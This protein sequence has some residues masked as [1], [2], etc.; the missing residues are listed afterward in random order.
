MVVT[1]ACGA[2][3]GVT[4]F[5]CFSG[6]LVSIKKS[7]EARINAKV[8]IYRLTTIGEKT[9]VELE[10][11]RAEHENFKKATHA[12]ELAVAKA[13]AE[14]AKERT[15]VANKALSDIAKLRE[16][17]AASKHREEERTKETNVAI[18]EVEKLRHQVFTAQQRELTALHAT[19]V[20]TGKAQIEID[21]LRR[22]L[23]DARSRELAALHARAEDEE[24]ILADIDNMHCEF[25]DNLYANANG[26]ITVTNEKVL[27][28]K[29]AEI[30]CI[31]FDSR[32]KTLLGKD[33][34]EADETELVASP[35]GA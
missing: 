7:E 10:D 1:L 17:L 21:N 13:R 19:S 12:R 28:T 27:P 15:A 25:V 26:P 9:R 35:F 24:K 5:A 2:G 32:A 8:E 20:A 33:P 30:K 34:F 23:L 29:P 31:A 16:E 3:V 6:L 4:G 14:E 22:E 18:C 11:L